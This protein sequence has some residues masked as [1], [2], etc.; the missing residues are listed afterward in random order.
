MEPHR[1]PAPTRIMKVTAHQRRKPMTLEEAILEMGDRTHYV[2]RGA[3][4]ERT[5]VIVRRADG[6]IDL[7]E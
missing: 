3:D 7:I 1:E 4:G 5:T 2:F 6:H